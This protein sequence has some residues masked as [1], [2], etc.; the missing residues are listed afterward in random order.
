MEKQHA[1]Q[2]D[3]DEQPQASTSSGK[4][5]RRAVA[6]RPQRPCPVAGCPSVN[7][8]LR[9]HLKC[10]HRSLSADEINEL[11]RTRLQME[12]ESHRGKTRRRAAS[13]RYQKPCPVAGCTSLNTDLR[14]H[15]LCC[16]RSL[17]TEDMDEMVKNQPRRRPVKPIKRLKNVSRYFK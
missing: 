15:L 10:C 2:P 9:R 3:D 5:R 11:V 13:S 1:E 12:V 14:K 6:S 8:D 7:A 4:P 16:H 17:S